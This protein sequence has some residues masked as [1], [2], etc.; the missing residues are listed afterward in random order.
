MG[1]LG[2]GPAAILVLGPILRVKDDPEVKRPLSLPND[3]LVAEQWY[4]FPPGD[5]R[6]SPG[7][8]SAIEAWRRVRPAEPI[9]VALLDAGDVANAPRTTTPDR[10]RSAAG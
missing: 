7:S 8:L 4:L 6:G 10:A 2:V 9:V 1:R 5:T 3:P